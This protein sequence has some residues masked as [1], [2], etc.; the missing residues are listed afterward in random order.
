SGVLLLWGKAPQVPT[1]VRIGFALRIAA[2]CGLLGLVGTGGFV[3]D[4]IAKPLESALATPG[5]AL[6]LVAAAAFGLLL[7][8]RTPL[9]AVPGR[10]A[11]AWKWFAPEP[12]EEDDSESEPVV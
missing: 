9:R 2:A 4:A 5:A 3:G 1:A 11:G 8:T 12:R 6:V 10:L 7:V